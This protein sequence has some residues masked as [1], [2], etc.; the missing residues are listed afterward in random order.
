M[1]NSASKEC[2]GPQTDLIFDLIQRLVVG[3]VHVRELAVLPP[4]SAA[5]DVLLDLVSEVEGIRTQSLEVVE[6]DACEDQSHEK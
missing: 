6:Q 2:F 4:L 5:V 1:L 3:H